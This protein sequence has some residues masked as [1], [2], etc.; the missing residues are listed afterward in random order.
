MKF[1]LF[2]LTGFFFINVNARQSEGNT[3]SVGSVLSPVFLKAGVAKRVITPKLPFL[4]TGYASRTRPATEKVHDLWAK[5]LFITSGPADK[6]VI[7]TTGVLGLTPQIHKEVTDVLYK[8]FGFQPSQVILNSSHTHSG[9]M[10]WPSLQMIGDFDAATI[11]SFNSYNAFLV[12]AIVEIVGEA[13]SNQFT[14]TISS[15]HGS[16]G[17]AMNRRQLVNGKIVNGKNPDGHKDHDVPV[18]KIA[19]AKGEIKAVLFGY[20]C[21]NTTVT[22][23]NYLINGDYAGFAQIE[24]EKAYPS[25]TAL[26]FTGCAGDQN[27]QPRG[28]IELAAQH[29]KTLADAVKDVLQKK[30]NAVNGKVKSHL[31]EVPL[32]FV[33]FDVKQYEAELAGDNPY[34]QRRARLM[35]EAVNRGYDVTAYNYPVQAMRIGNTLTFVSLAGEVVVDY[36]LRL[37]QMYPKENLFIAGYCNHVMGYIPTKKIL[38]EGGYE[39]GENLIYYGM[40]GPFTND[41]E[42]RIFSSLKKILSRLGVK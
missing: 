41:V 39:A 8:K 38:E 28:T 24:L 9:P 5:A 19:N 3:N 17:F 25:A 42:E 21:H 11:K 26:F 20:A 23:G 32:R 13:I 37:K 6:T 15:G 34:M 7:V 2:L 18:L 27:P 22:G 10:V 14:A 29:G 35:L 36:A 30:M 1:F 12:N 40:P 4:L 31:G 16:A 33:P